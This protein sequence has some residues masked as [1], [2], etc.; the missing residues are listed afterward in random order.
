MR[1]KNFVIIL[2]LT[3]FLCL[4]VE[5]LASR[6]NIKDLPEKYRKWVE[7][8]VIYIIRPTEKDVFL[9]MGTDREREIFIEA[10]WKQRDPTPGTPENEFKEEHYRRIAYAN[11]FFS[12]DTPR[13]GW[14]TDRGR[15]Y[16]VLGDP[17]DIDRYEES[18]NIYPVEVWFYQGDVKYG[19]PPHF[20]IAFFKRRGIGEYILYS[21][22]N[23]GPTKLL[24]KYYGNPADY[25]AAYEE[26]K[27]YDMELAHLS[28]TLIP[29]ER[30]LIGHPSLASEVMI[31]NVIDLPKKK[32]EDV[33]AEKLL[34]YKDIVE[35]EYTA[36][37]VGSD[38]LVSIIKDSSDIFFVH[39]SIDPKTLSIGSFE[40]RYYSY[41][42]LNTQV[43][44]I[45][46]KTVFQYQKNY[47][48]RFNKEQLNDIQK[49]SYSIQDMFPL[50]PGSYKLNVLLKNTVSKEFTSFEA[51]IFI[52]ELASLQMTSLLF[53]YKVEENP[54][55]KEFHKPF[56]IGRNQLFC[57]PKKVFITKDE[58]VVFFQ[59]YGLNQELEEEG[60]L[61][62]TFL[63][64]DKEFT[65]RTVKIKEI[66]DKTGFIQNFSLQSFPPGYYSLKV[67]LVDKEGKEI[68]SDKNNFSISYLEGITR[69]WVISKATPVTRSVEYSFILGN[70][71][72][73]K[74]QSEKAK[75]VLESVYR[76]NPLSL[77]FSYGF[78]RALFLLKEYK[79]VKEVL[80]PLL[81]NPQ[82]DYKFLSLLGRSCQA[83]QE[84]E[85]AI[86]YYKQ[87][88]THLGTNL[89]ILNS[90]GECYYLEGKNEEALAAW[91]KSLEIDPN[92][93]EIKEKVKSI[94][95][96]KL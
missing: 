94:K 96:N 52:P 55:S 6:K 26:L 77:K 74:G 72:L 16:I 67:A 46:G 84:Y 85:E 4:T 3:F 78:S 79:K 27:G 91:E 54:L 13:P 59:I 51:D 11:K 38:Y 30:P 41:F 80:K 39:F 40:D 24:R 61:I 73:N 58:L 69:P 2:I 60:S 34:K 88:L 15:I 33:Y 76:K 45:E 19:L 32:I 35:V 43:S 18:D 50:V 71:L 29:G 8:E 49:K 28:L 20:N 56:R 87:Y 89:L 1:K 9:Q 5:T 81:E 21:P 47:P 22:V 90:I 92:Q 82:D 64:E 25:E 7:E 37:Y 68:L 23:D 57:Q 95:E 36:N 17:I 42:E 53:S 93:Q 44:D 62:Y 86:Q 70:Q 65:T 83:L 75:A 66:R 14:K 31:S 10:F 48:L 63:K 12:R